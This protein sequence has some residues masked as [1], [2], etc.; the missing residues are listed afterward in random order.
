M[1]FLLVLRVEPL[2]VRCHAARCLQTAGTPSCR[3][4]DGLTK[5]ES[6]QD[7]A[8]EGIYNRAV[9]AGKGGLGRPARPRFSGRCSLCKAPYLAHPRRYVLQW[10][11]S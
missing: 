4:C 5:L 6:L 8:N 1:A 3:R 2:G 9:R 7:D 10:G 11:S